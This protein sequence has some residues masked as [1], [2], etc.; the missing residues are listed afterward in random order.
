[1]PLAF[2]LTSG[3]LLTA[4]LRFPGAR[5]LLMLKWGLY[6]IFA[7]LFAARSLS[8]RGES[9]A[10]LPR[11]LATF[12]AFHVAYGAGQAVGWVR[13]LGRARG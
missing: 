2:V 4:A 7:A 3:A 11:V 9:M 1:V 8:E 12:P 13:A 6:V 5:N 10:L